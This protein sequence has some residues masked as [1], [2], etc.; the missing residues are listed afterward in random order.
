MALI[1]KLPPAPKPIATEKNQPLAR[2]AAAPQK[3]PAGFESRSSFEQAIK[4]P[5]QLSTERAGQ[6][7]EAVEDSKAASA[8]AEEHGWG[9]QVKA[10]Y[11]AH[12]KAVREGTA[13]LPADEA[14]AIIDAAHQSPVLAREL[15]TLI[16]SPEFKALSPEDQRYAVE[17]LGAAK[18]P[19]AAG[20]SLATILASPEKLEAQDKYGNGLLQNLARMATADPLAPG[21]AEGAKGELINS[22]LTEIANPSEEVNQGTATTCTV[23][24]MQQGLAL[25]QPAEYARLMAGLTIEGHVDMMGGEELKLDRGKLTSEFGHNTTGIDDRSL[26][27]VIFQSAA[28][29]AA[30]GNEFWDPNSNQSTDMGIALGRGGDATHPGLTGPQREHILEQLFGVEYTSQYA[31]DDAS[32][33][34]AMEFL[35]GEQPTVRGEPLLVTLGPE[36]KTSYGDPDD[37]PIG[38]NEDDATGDGIHSVEFKGIEDTDGVQGLSDGDTVKYYDPA[39]LPHEQSCTVREFRERICAVQSPSQIAPEIVPGQPS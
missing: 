30:N 22:V 33:Q 20:R 36:G 12:M 38:A 21:L 16:Q 27:E 1:D 26:S 2:P 13:G 24:S 29:E 9:D 17:I 37:D 5:M 4:P 39:K 11:L 8:L 10:E 6:L 15:A 35:F 31:T 14:A 23:T 7:R 32:K 28:M 25:H 18:N 34:K 3:A 19:V